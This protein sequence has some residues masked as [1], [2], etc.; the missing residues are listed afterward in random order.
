VVRGWAS[1]TPSMRTSLSLA[2]VEDGRGAEMGVNVA[3]VWLRLGSLDP[4]ARGD[5]ISL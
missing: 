5:S 1:S 3:Y 2:S 4:Y